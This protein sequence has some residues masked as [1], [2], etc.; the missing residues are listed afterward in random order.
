MMTAKEIYDAMVEALPPEYIHHHE[1][2]LFVYI[3]PESS[4]IIQQSGL[5]KGHGYTVFRDQIS[6]AL[7]YDIAFA[8]S[9]AW[10]RGLGK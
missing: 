1:T 5:I 9:P 8:Y 2:D 3:T 7:S 4:K 6:G 10:E